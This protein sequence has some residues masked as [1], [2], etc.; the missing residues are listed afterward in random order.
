MY[1]EGVSCVSKTFAIKY[2]KKHKLERS[3]MIM[4]VQLDVSRD[5]KTSDE[6]RCENQRVNRAN[7][8]QRANR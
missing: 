1:P 8:N 2:V 6:I 5:F 4:S 7:R 3:E